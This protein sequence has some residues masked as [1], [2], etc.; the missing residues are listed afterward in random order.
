MADSMA[1]IYVPRLSPGEDSAYFDRADTRSINDDVEWHSQAQQDQTIF[2]LFRRKRAGFFLDMAANDPFFISNS[3]GLE[4]KGWDGICVEG[5]PLLTTHLAQYRK[6]AVVGA[7]L[8]NGARVGGVV[9]LEAN[10]SEG[11]CIKTVMPT[12]CGLL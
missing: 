10:P 4:K 11:M 8:S 12:R 9:T 3:R 5:N 2:H 1:V 7:A 6:C